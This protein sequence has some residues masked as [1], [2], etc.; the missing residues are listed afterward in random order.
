MRH[1][2]LLLLCLLLAAPL[3]AQSNTDYAG[4]MY[5]AHAHDAP[6]ASAA[7]LTPPRGDIV[8][9]EV[10][11]GT[12]DGT[13]LKGFLARPD[14]GPKGLPAVLLVHEWWGLNDN[15]RQMAQRFAGE[16]Y[17]ALAVDL[18]GGKVATT[19]DS[20]V[21]YYR[22]AMQNVPLGERNLAAG[23]SYLKQAGASTIGTVGW[24]FG[25]HWSLRAGLVGGPDVQAVVIYYGAPITDPADLGRLKAPVLGMYGGQD[26]GIPQDSVRA[27]QAQL[28]KLGLHMAVHVYPDA[29]HAFANPSGR[30]YNAEAA[31]DAW[32]RTLAFFKANLH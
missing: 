21:V 16:G 8:T 13:P 29:N 12:I 7:A 2:S 15:I 25:G 5:R 3:A 18:Y 32:Q 28:T 31:S 6:V 9:E 10:T 1:S 26:R 23:V 22:A 20:A 19:P 17:V 27:M 24:C 30:A 14:R 4:A 11:Y